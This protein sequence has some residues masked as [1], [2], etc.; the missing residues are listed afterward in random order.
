[1]AAL[2]LALCAAPALAAASGSQSPTFFTKFKWKGGKSFSGLIGSPNSHC[3]RDRKVILYRKKSGN[4]HKE[5]SDRTEGNGKFKI[6]LSGKIQEGK[7][8]AVVK[9]AKLNNGDVCAERQ[10]GSVKVTID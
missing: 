6:E 5:G 3:V 10:S 1:M 8:Y 4:A 7:Y 9:Q 2:A